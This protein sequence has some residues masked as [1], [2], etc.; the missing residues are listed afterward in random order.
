MAY[1]AR[2]RCP[3]CRHSVKRNG[4]VC[5]NCGYRLRKSAPTKRSS[6]SWFTDMSL[7]GKIIVIV[8]A[9]V[10]IKFLFM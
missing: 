2:P 7:T 5:K 6:F 10:V 4:Y 1:D 9:L 3:Q 8:V